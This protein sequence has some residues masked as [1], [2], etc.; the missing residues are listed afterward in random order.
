MS[1]SRSTSFWA[2]DAASYIAW[3]SA[4]REDLFKRR[5]SSEWASAYT[6]WG[7]T[8]GQPS[9]SF[10]SQIQN[11]VDWNCSKVYSTNVY[12]VLG[13]RDS[14]ATVFDTAITSDW[15][16]GLPNCVYDSAGSFA[17]TK[18]AFLGEPSPRVVA[19]NAV[20]YLTA[21]FFNH[22]DLSS[23][24]FLAS[25]IKQVRDV[26]SLNDRKNFYAFLKA[27]ERKFNGQPLLTNEQSTFHPSRF[28]CDDQTW[29]TPRSPVRSFVSKLA[30]FAGYS[31]KIAHYQYQSLTRRDIAWI[32]DSVLSG[33]G[34]DPGS[35][36]RSVWHL[37]HHRLL[38]AVGSHISPRPTPRQSYHSH[39][40]I[41]EGAILCGFWTSTPP[42]LA[43]AVY[44]SLSSTADN[45]HGTGGCCE[46]L[47]RR[48][49]RAH[50][51]DRKLDTIAQRAR[52][53]R[54]SSNRGLG[55]SARPVRRAGRFAYSTSC[56]EWGAPRDLHQRQMALHV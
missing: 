20:S 50:L 21:S 1:D 3:E 17:S 12:S 28:G 33:L 24:D 47:R 16:N 4:R 9:T 45:Q 37:L 30:S 29:L 2:E 43:A 7:V 22:A 38:E 25:K 15:S 13:D 19:R 5:L 35:P 42:P 27:V 26:Y 41:C 36:W 46:S 18:L 44:P 55:R 40:N 49:S 52:A 56:Q 51:F 54:L 39:E 11:V 31:H 6:V 14:I 53:T 32:W 48:R 34:S 23:D 8:N 10:T